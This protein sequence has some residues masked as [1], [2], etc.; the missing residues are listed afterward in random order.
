MANL[1]LVGAVAIKVRPD[2]T[3]FRREAD[4]EI[5]RELAGLKPTVKVKVKVTADT[6]EAKAEAREAKEEI[7]KQGLKLRVGV[8]YESIQRAQ[9]QLD[10]AIKH[11]TDEIIVVHL[12][13]DGSIEAAQR[14][15][16][17]MRENSKINFEFIPDEKGFRDVLARLKEIKRENIIK[18]VI[19][20]DFDDASI[21]AKAAEIQARLD[22]LRPHATVQL[23][24][25]NNRPSLE[26]A[27]AQIDAEL[28]KIDAVKVAVE[29]DKTQLLAKRAELEAELGKLPVRIEYDA[30]LAG[31]LALKAKLE[32][33]L[34]KLTIETKL[35]EASVREALAEVEAKI[36]AAELNKLQI[37]P[38][39]DKSAYLKALVGLKVLGKDVTVGIFVKLN[40]AS[41][42]L[43]A[44]KLTGLRAATRWTEQFA[45]TLGT[46]D[47]NLPIVAAAV[48]GLST[49]ASGVLTLTA[50]MF[51]LGNGIGEVVRMGGLLAPAM[52]LGLGATMLVLKAVFKDFGAAIH[53]IDA[54]F[55]R[56]PPS[57]QEAARTFRV[58]FAAAR[59]SMSKEFWDRASDGMLRFSKIA[60]PAL[61]AG[62]VQISGSLGGVFSNLLDSFN[63][64]TR[65]SGVKVFFEN[66]SRG[67]ELAQTGLADFMDAFLSLAA[68]GSTAFPRMGRAFN[69]FAAKF[70]SWVQRLAADGTLSRWIDIGIQGM[71]DI[72]DSAVSLVKVW[73]NIGQA[74]QAAGALTL[75]S[76]SQMLERLD[77]VTAGNRFQQ[78]MKNIFQG[79]REASDTFHKALGDL[80]P[81]M[82]VF[83][84]TV[85]DTLV[86][87][88]A[89]LGSF[90]RLIGDIFSS[91]A[92]N[93]GLT[94]FLTGVRTMFDQLRP[95]AGELV[96]ILQTFGQILGQVATDSGPLFRNLFQQLATVLTA[97]WTSLEQFLPSLIQ[98]G[99]SVVSILGP[100]LAD[101]AQS[102]IPAFARALVDLGPGLIGLVR[103]L[104]DAA[105]NIAN[106]ASA[107]PFPVLAGLVTWVLSISAALTAARTVL[108]L[109]TLAMEAFGVASAATAARMQLLIPG[110][111]LVL[112]AATATAAIG[113]TSLA[114]A[115]SS[116]AP[117]ANEYADAL[118]RDSKAAGAVVGA[119]GDVTKA[120]ILKKAADAGA[121][122]AAKRLGL[123]TE[124]VTDA[125]LG[126]EEAAGRARSAIKTARKDYDDAVAAQR[127]A[128]GSGFLLFG[129][130]G[131]GA[132]D[133]S[134]VLKDGARD[135]D[136]LDKVIS[137][138]SGS[139]DEAVS[140]I[141]ELDR[142]Q[143]HAGISGDGLAKAYRSLSE[144]VNDSTVAI[145]AA[146][147]A[148]SV[149]NDSFSSTPAKI[150][151]MRKT[152]D[153]LLGTNAK[154]KTAEALG[155]YVTGFNNL[156]ASVAPLKKEMENLGKSAYGEN[157]F[158]NVASGN[159]AVAQVNQA[160]V[161][162][163][164]NTWAGAKQAYD[165]AIQHGGNAKKAFADAKKF[166][167]DHKGDYDDLAERSG[168]AS[169][170][171][172]GQWK[173]LFDHEWILK[174]S[175]E[176]ATEAAA[177]AKA[178]IEIIG[179]QWDGRKFQ[180]LIDADPT[181]ALL[182]IKDPT[183]AAEY[184]VNK[185]WKARLG[186]L[187]KPAQDQ[188]KALLKLTDEEWTKGDFEAVLRA[189]EKVPGLTEAIAAIIAGA[190]ADY[191]AIIY[192]AVNHVSVAVARQQLDALAAR[193]T[194]V[195]DVVVNQ[196][197]TPNFVPRGGQ[198]I[199]TSANGSIMDR[200]GNGLHGFN[201]KYFANG[202]IERHIAQI[203]KPGGP[204][205]VWAE[206]ETQGEAY[207]PYSMSK[208][209]RS[210]AILRQVAKDFGYVLNKADGYANGGL[211]GNTSTTPTRTSQ[212]SVT[213]GTI[214]TVD[215]EMAVRKLQALQRDALA[216][217]G[218]R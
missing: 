175:L 158:L 74:A 18:E 182:A 78:N 172:Q 193:R 86:N 214:N 178:M 91:P 173:A 94:A 93:T 37:K 108:P 135:A 38:A 181:F 113:I 2:A 119:I 45:R 90:I 57:G 212:T 168:V 8:D 208:R 80:G 187:P 7:E 1:K 171:V 127:K 210:V 27:I 131:K 102:V 144:R 215:P 159:K 164:N 196:L 63:R 69:D 201:P 9:R 128:G 98:F 125:L 202:G 122:E 203:T 126:N 26:R 65:N 3:G 112:A 88:G 109:A 23:S 110:I 49:L 84:V 185:E 35:D 120:T 44:A 52:L 24:Y 68:L 213:V 162:Q 174:V 188:I 75:H 192:A 21:D 50:D 167:D 62:M 129:G 118:L 142:A 31:L 55:K 155:A 92:L 32:A 206:P 151:A 191:E 6:T 33:L 97:A 66:M 41:I 25:N 70:D 123:S 186:A 169:K 195:I 16:D 20:I 137:Q 103:F 99:T 138:S 132:F 177:K 166:V 56:L 133:V 180:A 51:A 194:S 146:T 184:F 67:L 71:K 58:V 59:E 157:G 141:Q 81:A 47:R 211:A 124:D 115:Q 148:S 40:N 147:A 43:A 165:N 200:F 19:E 76:F 13:D 95:A 79:A 106:F 134:K 217:A 107:I 96:T 160:L 183:A 15:L 154:Q 111:G 22:A 73:G 48:V 170:E 46:L 82:D 152:F 72:F 163:V 197:N 205:R 140:H 153:I 209:P 116:A 176:G 218:I 198:R 60:L 4:A 179:G 17:E 42:L 77:V 149:L 14:R 61:S 139:L 105:V 36:K 10:D 5:E 199:P 11:L 190:N 150:D 104:S 34:P 114:T 130:L 156:K 145:G 189:A 143:K 136:V 29:L 39:I 12:D 28:A 30:N 53:G 64:F 117:F 216:L 83:S 85:K 54:A 101:V 161:D 204:I 89:A 100:A 87:A 121:F 207:V